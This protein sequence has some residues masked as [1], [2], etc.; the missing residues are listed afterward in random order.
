MGHRESGLVRPASH[1][2]V[3]VRQEMSV[4][5]YN[6]PTATKTQGQR[7]VCRRIHLFNNGH[8]QRTCAASLRVVSPQKSTALFI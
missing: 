6:G 3:D 5:A 7:A 1:D 8:Q 2:F 4:V